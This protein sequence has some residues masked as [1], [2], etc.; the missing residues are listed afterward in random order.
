MGSNLLNF[1]HFKGYVKIPLKNHKFFPIDVEKFSEFFS[2][3]QTRKSWISFLR[4]HFRRRFVFFFLSTKGH[5]PPVNGI[6]RDSVKSVKLN[7]S[8]TIDSIK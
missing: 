3:M 7:P 5:G 8:N 1:L 4:Q 2:L 6:L